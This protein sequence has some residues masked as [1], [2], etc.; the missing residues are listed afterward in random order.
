[1]TGFQ[2]GGWILFAPPSSLR[3]PVDAGIFRRQ[4][5]PVSAGAERRSRGRPSRPE[6]PPPRDLLPSL[7]LCSGSDVRRS[8]VRLPWQHIS[9]YPPVPPPSL[10]L[11]APVGPQWCSQH[12]AAQWLQ[13]GELGGEGVIQHPKTSARSTADFFF[14]FLIRLFLWGSPPLTFAI[15][16]N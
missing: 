3:S 8:S 5:E 11:S 16:L 10:P 14:P 7:P 13:G 1:M 6:R 9:L 12:L 15:F 4:T 2:E